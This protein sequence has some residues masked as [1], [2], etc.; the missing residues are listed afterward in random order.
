MHR[1]AEV[2]QALERRDQAAVVALVQPDRR[3]V[4]DVEHA[5]EA[6][7]DLRGEPDALRLAARERRRAA[8]RAR[9]SS[10]PT[11]SR[12][13]RRSEISRSTRA[14]IMRSVSPSSRFATNSSA[15]RTDFS[16]NWS[17]LSPPTV[18]AS[19]SGLQ[20]RAVAGRARAERHVLLD[21]LL[22]QRRLGLAVAALQAGDDALERRHVAARAPVPGGPVGD[23]DLLIAGAPQEQVPLVLREVAPGASTS[24]S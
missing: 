14:P 3:L 11:S 19:D 12:N 1:V 16:V 17:M 18:T 15:S 22:L 20:P 10:R 2:A 9:G 23:I 13:V 5:H 4:E 6:R 24:I 8:R 7:P 21:P